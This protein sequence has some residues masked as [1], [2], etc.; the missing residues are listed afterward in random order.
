MDYCSGACLFGK[1][2]FDKCIREKQVAREA[3]KLKATMNIM[4][5]GVMENVTTDGSGFGV[6]IDIGTT[7]LV[8]ALYDLKSAKQIA[9]VSCLNSQATLG[10][11]VI[12]RIKYAREIED[13]L[14]KLHRAIVRDLMDLLSQI[15]G[16]VHVSRCVVTAN[17]T[18]MHLF[19]NIHPGTMGVSP[20]TPQSLF[21]ES[22]SGAMLGLGCEIKLVKCISSFV[23]AD[24]TS[25]ILACGMTQKNETSLLLDIGTNGE[26]ALAHEG[27]LFV[28][29]TAAG[30]AFEGASI[31][32][33]M[34]G[35][36]GAI[37][38]VELKNGLKTRTIADKPAQGI[39][40]SGL[41][42][43][44]A[45]M[46]E[47]GIIDDMGGFCDSAESGKFYLTEQVYISQGDIREL[48]AAKAAIAAGVLTLMHVSGVDYDEVEHVYL[49]GGFGNF[50]DPAS[51]A[52]IG[53]FPMEVLPKISA[54]G[55]AALSG[56]SL[57]LL[58]EEYF[59]MS[60]KVAELGEHVELGHN[61]Y[62][63]EKYIDCMSFED[64]S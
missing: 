34:A 18:M 38:K 20:F 41:L 61:P 3:V 17:T 8:A 9:C 29:S 28:T 12:S 7:T 58:N 51:A 60:T 57:A 16:D 46:L 52:K 32:C 27:K 56:A 14:G 21:G 24:V 31:A 5:H 64:D 44:V 36:K 35:V 30:P 43:A 53:I 4:T 62:F 49:A 37:S 48:Q 1:C 25:A 26:V 23:G 11:D 19:A 45:I 2:P 6:A 15:S 50:L 39:C 13:G 59:D 33:G 63:M 10:P 47:A 55:N 42:D 40:G 22:I 54:V